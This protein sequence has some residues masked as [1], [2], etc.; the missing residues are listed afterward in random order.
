MTLKDNYVNYSTILIKKPSMYKYCL[1]TPAFI[2]TISRDEDGWVNNEFYSY[3]NQHYNNVPKEVS[4]MNLEKINHF[5]KNNLSNDGLIVEIG[6]WRNPNAQTLTS[7]ELFFKKKPKGCDYLGIDIEDRPHV[8]KI[9]ENK[10]HFLQ[11]DSSKTD[12]IKTHIKDNFSKKIDFL[13]I[14]GLHTLNHVGKEIDLISIVKKGGVIGF[15]DISVHCGPNMWIDAFDP[16]MFD[17]YKF[18]EDNDWGIGFL[19]KKFD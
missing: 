1:Y 6:V 3:T 12:D 9:S 16:D 7:T 15:H 11:I 10:I 18:R 14:D 8:R 13:F 5:I 19:V 2:D 4:D 17:I